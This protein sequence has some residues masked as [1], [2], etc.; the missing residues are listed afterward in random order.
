MTWAIVFSDDA[1]ADVAALRAFD[2][3]RILD[4]ID[5]H[6]AGEPTSL[7]ARKKLIRHETGSV[8]QLRVGDFRVFYD[9]EVAQRRVLVQGVRHKGR[10]TTREIL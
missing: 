1:V 3:T 10:K 4:A 5:E 9:V 8:Y 7:T 2:R 6:L